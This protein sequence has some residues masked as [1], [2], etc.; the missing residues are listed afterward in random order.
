MET[1]R[2]IYTKAFAYGVLGAFFI[3]A[4]LAGMRWTGLT[5][6]NFSVF[7]GSMLTQE[8]S[9]TTWAIGAIWHLLNGGVFGLL[10]CWIFKRSAGAGAGR[11][12]M[13]GFVNWL[14]FAVFMAFSPSIHPLIPSEITEPGFFAINYGGLTAVIL[15]GLHLIFGYIIG[16]GLEGKLPFKKRPRPYIPRRYA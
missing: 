7:L 9:L 13:L 1:K 8:F 2:S 16:N 11:G 4:L 5:Q 15:F 14:A 3:S 6:F 10:Y 12:V